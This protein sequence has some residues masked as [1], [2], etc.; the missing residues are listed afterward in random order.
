MNVKSGQVKNH[1][2]WLVVFNLESNKEIQQ[3]NNLVSTN[4]VLFGGFLHQKIFL[5]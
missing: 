2:I 1:K 5:K 4:L 3:K